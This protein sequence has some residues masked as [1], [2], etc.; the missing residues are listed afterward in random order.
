MSFVDG[1]VVYPLV[2]NLVLT[3]ASRLLSLA[4]VVNKGFVGIAATLAE[5]ARPV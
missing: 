2:A 3:A 1:G 4:S 5:V